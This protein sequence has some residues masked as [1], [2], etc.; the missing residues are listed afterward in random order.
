MIS[1]L[2]VDDEKTMLDF[3]KPF[4]ERRGYKVFYVANGK[5]GIEVVKRED[6]D[7]VLLDLGLPDMSGSDVLVKI[8]NLG[9]PPRVVILTG[10]GDDEIRQKVTTLGPD[11]YFTKP[12]RLP[13]IAE[14]IESLL[15]LGQQEKK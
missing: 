11:A 3:G 8:K 5:D 4:F 2:I 10:F 15:P 7:A 1:L 12:C 9:K 13:V 14:K 6:P